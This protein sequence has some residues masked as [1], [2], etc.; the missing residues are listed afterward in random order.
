M[1]ESRFVTVTASAV[2]S[3]LKDVSA[4]RGT[5]T[6]IP[7]AAE[8]AQQQPT[9]DG[10]ISE[11]NPQAFVTE[12][13]QGSGVDKPF[14]TKLAAKWDMQALYIALD[15]EGRQLTPVPAGDTH[16]WSYDTIELFFDLWNKRRHLR[17]HQA[18]QAG[19][20]LHDEA[21][22]GPVLRNY[23]KD[24]NG[25][26]LPPVTPASYKLVVKQREN[27]FT[28]EACLDWASLSTNRWM[29]ADAMFTPQAGFTFGL[30]ASLASRSLLGARVKEYDNPSKWG[31]LK[32]LAPGETVRTAP[33]PILL[34]LS[35]EYSGAF[36]PLATFDV[37]HADGWMLAKN[38]T[39]TDTGRDVSITFAG[40]GKDET[41]QDKKLRAHARIYLTPQKDAG[42]EPYTMDERM[43]LLVEYRKNEDATL[44]LYAK[45]PPQKNWGKHLWSATVAS[46]SFPLTV[47]LHVDKK[48]YRVSCDKTLTPQSGSLSGYH[49]LKPENWSRGEDGVR[50]GIKSCFATAPGFVTISSVEIR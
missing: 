29:T 1:R 34:D 48:T 26:T 17:D 3:E 23:P 47:T 25:V 11:W 10:D 2:G 35:T 37:K 38:A 43:A 21:S 45:T 9:L 12:N 6:H 33:A 44:T 49:E 39:V 14:T 32:L 42:N 20:T 41:A 27:G 30:E 8:Y 36:A 7:F 5:V 40:F 15:V 22:G 28:D 4:K 24:P 13:H 50:F 16:W 18:V 46:G 19:L 31:K